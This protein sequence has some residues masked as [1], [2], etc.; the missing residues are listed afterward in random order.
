VELTIGRK[1]MTSKAV[2]GKNGLFDFYEAMEMEDDYAYD[3][4]YGS[5]CERVFGVEG[6]G[7]YE[8]MEMQDN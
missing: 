1:C 5:V 3:D 6:W 4:K 2:A 7:F 8:A